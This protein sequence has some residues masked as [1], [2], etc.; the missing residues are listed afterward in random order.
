MPLRTISLNFSAMFIR[1]MASW[2]R[3]RHWVPILKMS[4][5]GDVMVGVSRRAWACNE[6]ALTT[7]AEYNRMREGT[8]HITLPYLA[9]GAIVE[10]A[11]REAEEA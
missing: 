9:D 1:P 6:N 4:M 11:L 7:A 5:P 3:M 2:Y 10:A 8:D